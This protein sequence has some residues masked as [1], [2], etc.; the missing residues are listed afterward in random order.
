MMHSWKKTKRYTKL[1]FSL[2]ILVDKR[3]KRLKKDFI[4]YLSEKDGN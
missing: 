2:M 1:K 4:L 3:F